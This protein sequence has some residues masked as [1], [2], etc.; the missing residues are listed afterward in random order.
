MP[1]TLP[2]YPPIKRWRLIINLNQ[3]QAD[4]FHWTCLN[5]S[6]N[7]TRVVTNLQILCMS[8]IHLTEPFC[9]LLHHYK[10]IEPVEFFSTNNNTGDLQQE[11]ISLRPLWGYQF[12]LIGAIIPLH[13]LV[14]SWRRRYVAITRGCRATG[15]TA[16]TTSFFV[17]CTWGPSFFF[18]YLLPRCTFREEILLQ[19][20]L[21]PDMLLLLFMAC[22]YHF[23][24]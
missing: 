15:T 23:I 8:V 17:C 7:F 2:R 24:S 14:G 3:R 12:L 22:I 10:R 19:L 4:L 13:W 16:T 20:R 1:L 21:L 18:S 11:E 6:V 9:V 5:Q